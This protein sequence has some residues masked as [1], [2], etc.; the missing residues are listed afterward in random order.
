MHCLLLRRKP[1]LFRNPKK[2]LKRFQKSSK[3]LEDK[4]NQNHRKMKSK[5]SQL[6]NLER[7]NS[8][9]LCLNQRQLKLKDRSQKTN[10]RS[11]QNLKNQEEGLSLKRKKK[12][13]R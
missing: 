6:L 8:Q 12:K 1:T 3:Q 5:K 2:S 10:L 4:K 9:K 7:R 13:L 11:Q